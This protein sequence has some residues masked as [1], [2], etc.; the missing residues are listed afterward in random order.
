M[1]RARAKSKSRSLKRTIIVVAAGCVLVAAG[2]TLANIDFSS[3][4]VHRNR[5]SIDTVQQGTLEIKISANGQLLP[6]N[7]EY[8]ASQV[9]GRV[10]K[11]Y[12]KAGAVVEVG[13]LLVELTNPQL[14]DSAEEA[15]S[16]WEGAVTELKASEAQLQTGLL[17]QRVVRT[18]A[19]FDLERAQ[20]K[21]EA[22]ARLLGQHIIPE[23]DYKRDKLTVDQL[24][25]T[26]AFEDSRL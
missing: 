21:L 12:V 5:L 20:V 17:N 18:Q 14:I 1:D 9:S 3:K 16:A 2:V 11:T 24:T 13:Q 7:V 19:Q 8:I 26:L 4:R 15:H 10:A 23:I 25:Q 22:E 6:K